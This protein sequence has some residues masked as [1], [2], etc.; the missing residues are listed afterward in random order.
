MQ[1]T[2]RSNLLSVIGK[3][4]SAWFLVPLIAGAYLLATEQLDALEIGFYSGFVALGLLVTGLNFVPLKT[5]ANIYLVIVFGFLPL[6]AYE[7]YVSIASS[8]KKSGK[9]GFASFD[10]RTRYQVVMDLRKANVEAYP[11]KSPGRKLLEVGDQEVMP[12]CRG[13]IRDHGTLQ[14]SRPVPGLRHR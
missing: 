6:Y 9:K 11:F 5:K 8:D 4:L 2:Q 3:V 10:K 1:P 7:A 14:R 13:S 12:L